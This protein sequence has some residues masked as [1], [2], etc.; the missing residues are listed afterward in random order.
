MYSYHAV[1]WTVGNIP[2]GGRAY[3]Y[4][5]LYAGKPREPWYWYLW[6]IPVLGALMVVVA[7]RA[8]WAYYRKTWQD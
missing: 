3:L 2:S 8:I 6:A 7:I 5:Q 1:R 4:A